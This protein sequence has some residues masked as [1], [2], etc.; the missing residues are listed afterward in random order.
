[1]EHLGYV[2]AALVE[3]G[4]GAGSAVAQ[5]T[6]RPERGDGGLETEP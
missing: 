1:M 4:E 6:E 3:R 2:M 5:T